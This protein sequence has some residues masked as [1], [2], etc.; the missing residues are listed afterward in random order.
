MSFHTSKK[1]SVVKVRSYFFFAYFFI[2][3]LEMICNHNFFFLLLGITGGSDSKEC[4][5]NVEDPRLDPWFGKI[6]WRREW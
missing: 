5:H 6:L 4:A 3:Y 2:R 1:P